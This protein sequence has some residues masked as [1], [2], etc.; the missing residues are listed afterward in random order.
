MSSETNEPNAKQLQSKDREQPNKQP[1]IEPNDTINIT[2]V[3]NDCLEYIFMYLSLFD[4]LNLADSCNRLRQIARSTYA[5]KYSKKLVKI[6]PHFF[7]SYVQYAFAAHSNITIHEFWGSLKFLRCFGPLTSVLSTPTIRECM[8]ERKHNEVDRYI[9][10]YCAASVIDLEFGGNSLKNLIN[11][12]PNVET[13]QFR[14]LDSQCGWTDIFT[15]FPN[16]RVLKLFNWVYSGTTVAN[17]PHLEHLEV[18]LRDAGEETVKNLATFFRMN[19]Q[20]RSLIIAG[21]YI[22]ECLLAAS[23]CSQLEF[24]DICSGSHKP[25]TNSEANPIHFKS[26]K[27]FQIFTGTLKALVPSNISIVFDQ[28]EEIVIEGPIEQDVIEFISKYSSVPKFTFT[29]LGEKFIYFTNGPLFNQVAEALPSVTELHVM[30]LI[31]IDNVFYTMDECK[32]L[33]KFSFGLH[34][35]NAYDDFR[36]QLGNEWQSSNHMQLENGFNILQICRKIASE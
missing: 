5:S 8:S 24:L 19:Q 22:G 36:K 3:N 32:S 27:K 26:V 13:L 9:S 12:F 14:G 28:L 31:S 29:G 7:R 20:L 10:E 34:G 6:Y 2:D 33:K 21:K 35:F 25:S 23:E 18:G 4:L 16:V 30:F 11:Q 17:F 15:H 1:Y